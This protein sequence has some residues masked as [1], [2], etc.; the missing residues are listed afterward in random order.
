MHTELVEAMLDSSSPV[1]SGLLGASV[2][3]FARLGPLSIVE[4][5]QFARLIL[6]NERPEAGAKE[7]RCLA[8]D[9][10]FAESTRAK[11]V[12]VLSDLSHRAGDKRADQVGG[13]W[14]CRELAD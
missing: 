2:T 10:V 6:K 5:D 14:S 9:N 12:D 8:V 11:L 3:D 1:A 4:A 13:Q 7:W